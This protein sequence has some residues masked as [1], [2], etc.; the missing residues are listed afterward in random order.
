MKTTKLPKSAALMA[1]GFLALGLSG[2][3]N[4]QM[5][6][7][8]LGALDAE[9]KG[10]AAKQ[11]QAEAAQ[12]A[13]QDELA[14]LKNLADQFEKASAEPTPKAA[15]GLSGLPELK[16]RALLLKSLKHLSLEKEDDIKAMVQENSAEVEGYGEPI[17]Q[18]PDFFTHP[19]SAEVV[20][21]IRKDG[22]SLEVPVPFR[23]DWE[24]NW[25]LPDSR[26]VKD[27]VMIAASGGSVG[28]PPA[29]ATGSGGVAAGSAPQPPPVV[30]NT[31]PKPQPP[32]Q[33]PPGPRMP[34][35]PGVSNVRE[36]DLTGK[37]IFKEP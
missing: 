37:D 7:Q 19:Y 9:I 29:G 23:A 13:A 32:P 8:R 3:G 18:M 35:I 14:R 36:V 6:E 28:A 20:V 31:P 2:C 10:M 26:T 34:N 5:L 1:A 11:Q 12:A 27:R 30:A 22:Q 16:D 24:G 17:L 21:R 15:T 4:N 33:P 25:Q